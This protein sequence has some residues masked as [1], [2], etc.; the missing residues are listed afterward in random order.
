VFQRLINDEPLAAGA[1]ER[2]ALIRQWHAEEYGRFCAEAAPGE[3]F[4]VTNLGSGPAQEVGEFIDSCDTWPRPARWTLIDQAEESLSLAYANLYPKVSNTTP[5]RELRCIHMSFRQFIREPENT[6]ALEPQQL[7]YSSGLF[8][9]LGQATAAGLVQV[10]YEKLAPGGLL[11]VGNALSPNDHFWLGNFVLDWPL[12]FR[13]KAEVQA[14]AEGLPG[15]EK[16]EIIT[17]KA[18][19]HYLLRI[20]KGS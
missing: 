20:R 8:D 19:A 13:N 14:L 1:R 2:K 18:G 15:A 4:R 11:V 5:V 17:E 7:I 9:Y 10:L 16:V 6:L 3:V 12:F